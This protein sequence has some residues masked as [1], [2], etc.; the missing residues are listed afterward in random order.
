MVLFIILV[1]RTQ[2]EVT[3]IMPTFGPIAGGTELTVIGQHFDALDLIRLV[4]G[5]DHIC[6][7]INR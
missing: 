2:P 7:P 5:Q 4:I 3:S 1:L 6:E